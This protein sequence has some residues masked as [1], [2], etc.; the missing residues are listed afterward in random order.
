M[1]LLAG[2]AGAFLLAA[3]ALVSKRWD[4]KRRLLWDKALNPGIE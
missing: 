2:I 3:P 4:G 1:R